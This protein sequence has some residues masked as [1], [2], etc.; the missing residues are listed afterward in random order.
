MQDFCENHCQICIFICTIISFNRFDLLLKISTIKT[1]WFFKNFFAY[2]K[3]V[4][5]I[6]LTKCVVFE[7]MFFIY[8]FE[9]IT[10]EL[11]FD[12]AYVD[13]FII[14]SLMITRFFDRWFFFNDIDFCSFCFC[15]RFFQ[16]WKINRKRNFQSILRWVR[17]EICSKFR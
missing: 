2:S 8:Q 11:L 7:K 14:E 13:L 3:I 4:D 10:I 16:N 9:F 5:F 12:F 1:F 6:S 15:H 17:I